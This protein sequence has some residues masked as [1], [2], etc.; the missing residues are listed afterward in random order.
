MAA[1]SIIPGQYGLGD[2]YIQKRMYDKDRKPILLE[3][4]DNPFPHIALE[5]QGE[6]MTV[7]D[8]APQIP[9]ADEFS[10]KLVVK[11]VAGQP[12]LID[13]H[14]DYIGMLQ[15][16]MILENAY[17]NYAFDGVVTC[18]YTVATDA[19]HLTAVKR[20]ETARVAEIQGAGVASH[21]RVRLLRGGDLDLCTTQTNLSTS[22][23]DTTTLGHPITII[24]RTN[25]EGSGL[26]QALGKDLG[27]VQNY[28]M[29]VDHEIELTD[30]MIKTKKFAEDPG[31]AW[32]RQKVTG[33]KFFV[34]QI[35]RNCLF[36]TGRPYT[37]SFGRAMHETYGFVSQVSPVAWRGINGNN[38]S[39]INNALGPMADT[40]RGQN[41]W[42][43]G[44][45]DFLDRF[46]GAAENK[47][48]YNPE[49]TE[50]FG[51]S[52][53]TYTDS[54]L[55]TYNL[56]RDRE[57][58]ENKHWKNYGFV[59]N[60]NYLKFA[61]FADETMKFEDNMQIAG[62]RVRH[63]RFSTTMGLIGNFRG[64]A[65]EPGAQGILYWAN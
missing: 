18:V 65:T 28:M 36:G 46:V 21:T 33:N 62:D 26:G 59:V 10:F 52:V 4:F 7:Y 57:M 1:N 41:R 56:A 17:I 23:W 50:K 58:T 39:A 44:G 43:I 20:T 53:Q 45:G 3:R 12:N 30:W 5:T 13:V 63:G 55:I 37:T 25:H 32:V 6:K 61:V 40:G 34:R 42:I 11:S 29:Y 2:D 16:G 49:A 48:V 19:N 8:I 51:I 35:T 60:F 64:T 47:V 27:F 14:N 9:E 22:L 38:I 24:S 31:E 15:E 54:R